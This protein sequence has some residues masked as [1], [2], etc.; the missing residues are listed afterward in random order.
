MFVFLQI[1][2]LILFCIQSPFC[3][4][5]SVPKATQESQMSIRPSVSLSVC[6]LQKPLSLSELLLS[7]NE[8]IN[9]QAY[10]PSI[11]YLTCFH[12]F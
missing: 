4:E 5:F 7:T 9:H 1:I 11:G 3:I 10:Q 8:H 6:L 12:D 2:E